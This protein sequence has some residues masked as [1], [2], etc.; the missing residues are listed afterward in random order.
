MPDARPSQRIAEI[1]KELENLRA[2]NLSHPEKAAE[3]LQDGLGQLQLSLKELL[4]PI[5]P[6]LILFICYQQLKHEV[7]LEN[8]IRFAFSQYMSGPLIP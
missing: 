1:S 3:M 5:L 2:Q 4:M 7:Y 8:K 6:Y